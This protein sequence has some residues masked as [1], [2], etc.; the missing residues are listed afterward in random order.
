[1]EATGVKT[2]NV[3]GVFSI[4]RRKR[5]HHDVIIRRVYFAATSARLSATKPKPPFCSK[6]SVALKA[7]STLPP[8][9]THNKR[10]QS[11]RAFTADE[12]SKV[13]LVSTT[14]Q[15][16]SSKVPTTTPQS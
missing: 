16:S 12:R 15:G 8:Q 11:T 13:S 6:R 14:A 2:T 4:D 9:R 3:G 5:N 10:S 7:R 1:M